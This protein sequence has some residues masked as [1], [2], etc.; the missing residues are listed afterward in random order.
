MARTLRKEPRSIRCD[1]RLAGHLSARNARPLA[2]LGR[3]SRHHLCE[4]ALFVASLEP[5][6]FSHSPQTSPMVVERPLGAIFFRRI[7]PAQPNAIDED[8]STQHAPIVDVRLATGL[9][10]LGLQ[11]CHPRVA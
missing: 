1:A 9:R 11:T 4:D 2:V 7:S 6:A 5:L 8:N 3:Q 10:K